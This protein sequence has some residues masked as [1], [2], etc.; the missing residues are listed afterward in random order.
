LAAFHP[1]SSNTSVSADQKNSDT[2]AVA[3]R[4][5][6]PTDERL[7]ISELK[8]GFES[9]AVSSHGMSWR[10]ASGSKCMIFMRRIF[11]WFM[12]CCEVFQSMGPVISVM[13]SAQPTEPLP[14]T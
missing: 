11:R 13:Q 6:K 10:F 3:G 12:N 7:D 5:A 9:L 8:R 14:E 1:A 4:Q 2:H